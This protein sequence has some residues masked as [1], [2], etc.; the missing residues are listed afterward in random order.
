MKKS[1]LV[2]APLLC[3]AVVIGIVTMFATTSSSPAK[4]H[5][6]KTASV[7]SGPITNVL[8]LGDQLTP[9]KGQWVVVSNPLNIDSSGQYEFTATVPNA[10]LSAF[11]PTP[12]EM[13]T[14]KLPIYGIGMT[15]DLGKVCHVSGLETMNINSSGN[16]NVV[17]P[18]N[19]TVTQPYDNST[20]LIEGN[21]SPK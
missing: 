6:S 7:P 14:G 10:D 3:L 11:G 1:L 17:I 15:L 12:S 13:A 21:S 2:M 8:S 19:C 18:V 5:L 9:S 4:V 16:Y 20:I